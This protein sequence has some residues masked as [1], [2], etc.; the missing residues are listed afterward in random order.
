M[1]EISEE[2]L[3]GPGQ[4]RRYGYNLRRKNTGLVEAQTTGGKSTG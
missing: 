2:I 4:R 1:Y 3:Q